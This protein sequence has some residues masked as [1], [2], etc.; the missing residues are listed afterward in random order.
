MPFAGEAGVSKILVRQYFKTFKYRSNIPPSEGDSDTKPSADATYDRVE[1]TTTA[2]DTR[3][4]RCTI[5]DSAYL[6]PAN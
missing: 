2:S 4:A 1:S 6:G 3:A 5:S